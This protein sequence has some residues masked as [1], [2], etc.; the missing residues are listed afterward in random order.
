MN[1]IWKNYPVFFALPFLMA[2]LA[3]EQAAQIGEVGRWAVMLGAC[4]IPAVVSPSFFNFKATQHHWVLLFF[5]T[6]AIS[7]YTWSIGPFYSL[8][9]SIS[10]MLL[11]I[12]VFIGF[13]SYVQTFTPEALIKRLVGTIAVF[14]ALNLYLSL[15]L[16]YSIGFGRFQGFFENPNGVGSI[17]GLAAPLLFYLAVTTNKWIWRGLFGM[18]IISLLLAGSRG[19][20]LAALL[21]TGILSIPHLARMKA[22][23]FISGGAFLVFLTFFSQTAYFEENVMREET[24]ETMSNRSYFWDLGKEYISDR[25]LLGYGFGSDADIHQFHGVALVDMKLRGYGVMSS[26]L[27]LAVQIGIP[28]TVL[29][30]GYFIVSVVISGLSAWRDPKVMAYVGSTAGGLL[31]GIG[32]SVHY[33]A[34]NAFGFL[35]WCFPLLLMHRLDEIEVM[36]RQQEKRRRKIRIIKKNKLLAADRTAEHSVTY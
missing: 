36:K 6:V 16:G 29:F 2:A 9:R 22:Q 7:S 3:W 35:F 14:L 12:A 20:L 21:A 8:M 17:A 30:Y 5:L 34:G 26:Y 4:V 13:G 28:L 1:W 27:G 24:L 15:A 23:I 18:T 19:P 11:C 33:S 32:E 10:M 25:P 31:I